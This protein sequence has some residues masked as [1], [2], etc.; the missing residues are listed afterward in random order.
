M[1]VFNSFTAANDYNF[2]ANHPMAG[3]FSCSPIK[4]LK[5]FVQLLWGNLFKRSYGFFLFLKPF[6]KKLLNLDLS[7]FMNTSAH[8]VTQNLL[9]KYF[10]TGFIDKVKQTK[11][12]NR[13]WSPSLC[14]SGTACLII[15]ELSLLRQQTGKPFC[16]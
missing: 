1:M 5:A 7:L 14:I 8:K 6:C 15:C 16:S 3:A 12:L 2:G 13:I 9:T 10:F 11:L 4:L